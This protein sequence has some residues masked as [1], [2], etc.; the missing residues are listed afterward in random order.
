MSVK[1]EA[2]EVLCKK[3]ARLFGKD[4]ASM[5]ENTR[6]QEDLQC[7]SVNFVQLGSALEDEFEVEI[8]FMKFQEMKT[9]GEAGE[10]IGKQ[11]GE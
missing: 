1:S 9:F 10:Y 6:F 8:P 4:A 5:N 3:A 7:K 2:V 11:L